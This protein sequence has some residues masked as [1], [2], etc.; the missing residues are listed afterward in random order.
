MYNKND[1]NT[2]CN[3]VIRFENYTMFIDICCNIIY[4]VKYL[5]ILTYL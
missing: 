2:Y 5:Y 1:K 3:L 4:I